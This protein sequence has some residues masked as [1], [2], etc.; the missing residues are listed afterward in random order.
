[1]AKHASAQFINPDLFHSG[2]RLSKAPGHSGGG[3][4]LEK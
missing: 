4:D 2:T 3:K 1:M